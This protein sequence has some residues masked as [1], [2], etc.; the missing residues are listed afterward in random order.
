MNFLRYRFVT[1]LMTSVLLMGVGALKA[2]AATLIFQ[3]GEIDN[4]EAPADPAIPDPRIIPLFEGDDDQFIWFDQ[5]PGI[6]VG[7][8]SRVM[9]TF[10]NLP[11]NIIG[12]TL[13]ISVK[14]GT[15][16]VVNAG[17]YTDG[18]SIFTGDLETL[19]DYI[20]YGRDF[21]PSGDDPGFLQDTIW[22]PGDSAV[23]TLDLSALPL[24]EGGT[25]N[26]IPYI[27][28]Y[29][30][31]NVEINDETAVDYMLLTIETASFGNLT[32]SNPNGGE[33]LFKGQ[34]YTITWNSVNVSGNIQ[35]DL[36]KGGTEPENMVMQLAAAT[37]NDGEYPFNIPNSLA[38]GNDYLIRISDEQG[39]VW[40]F[41]DTYFTIQTDN[42]WVT[43]QGN[44][45]YNGTPLCAM[46]L[47]NGQYMFSCGENQGTYEL[48]VPLDENGEITLFAFV[49]GLA[50][51]KVTSEPS[52]LPSNIEMELASPDSKTPTV[53]STVVESIDNPG[54][55]EIEG[56]VSLEG[57]PLCAMVL[58]NG[59]YMFSC[60]GDGSYSL[61]VLLDGNGEITLF[62]FV[63]GLQPYKQTLIP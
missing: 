27:D 60:S 8:E 16:A 48:D 55:V 31:L 42:S 30:F 40:D 39:M 34:D 51:F 7:P 49:D 53:T 35:I 10:I 15:W 33:S 21:G 57:I 19:S 25:I 3:A 14:A 11:E 32:I 12:V 45:T 22:S 43:I 13:T 56:S 6:D 20:S 26:F 47:A 5:I 41:S 2:K 1:I 61:D 38:D 9:H 29:H 18:F 58:A 4:F 17:L 37:E 23:F 52:S 63:D 59:Q 50:P 46:V 62:T 24:I 28:K 44:V 54:W 36:Y